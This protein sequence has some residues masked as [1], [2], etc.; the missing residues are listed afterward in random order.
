MVFA[1]KIGSR[2]ER[3][4]CLTSGRSSKHKD[5]RAEQAAFFTSKGLG[6]V[7]CVVACD[8]VVVPL[9]V[10]ICDCDCL[11]ER[12]ETTSHILEIEV[13]ATLRGKSGSD[14]NEDRT[15]TKG[16]PKEVGEK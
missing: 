16:T 4:E 10:C 8:D 13:R 1:L 12:E 3:E 5:R 7:A 11:W 9:C 2:E 14:A 6:S 15:A